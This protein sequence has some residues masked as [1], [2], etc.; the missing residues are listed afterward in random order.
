VQTDDRGEV[1]P[2]LEAEV[3]ASVDDGDEP[4]GRGDGTTGSPNRTERRSVGRWRNST[5][6]VTPVRASEASARIPSTIVPKTTTLLASSVLRA[7]T[8]ARRRRT[9]GATEGNREVATKTRTRTSRSS[10]GQA[11]GQEKGRERKN[12]R[13]ELGDRQVPR[14]LRQRA[15]AATRSFSSFWF[16]A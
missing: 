14:T 9:N 15:A 1:H 2:G 12:S 5:Y 3:E 13:V 6:L 16:T 8:R 11:I 10:L 4:R 7:D